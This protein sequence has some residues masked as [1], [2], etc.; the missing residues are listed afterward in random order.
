MGA[1]KNGTTDQAAIRDLIENWAKAVRTRNLDGLLVKHS[2]DILMFDVLHR[3]NQKE[4]KRIRILG[5]CSLVGFRIPV[6]LT[7]AR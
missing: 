4:S 6:S 7:F 2:P 3:C 5:I 1:S